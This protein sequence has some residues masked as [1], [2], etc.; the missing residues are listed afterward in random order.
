MGQDGLCKMK[1]RRVS[2]IMIVE[3]GDFDDI[4]AIA[5][6]YPGKTT[7]EKRRMIRE[8]L[9]PE[10]EASREGR[11]T[12][13]LA[14]RDGVVVGTVQVVWEDAEEEPALLPPG[15]AVVHHLGTHP[16]YRRLGIG[17][18]LMEEAES[19]A[20][21]RKVGE[22]TL[23]VEPENVEAHRLYEKWGF[24]D[25]LSYRGQDGEPIVGMKKR[26]ILA[27]E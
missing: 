7:R 9:G 17:R 22:L 4:A 12:I 16:D 5:E 19:L 8:S 21:A 2:P 24:R 20:R 23:G 6:L 14:R 13:L 25:F 18:R 11:R 15:A 3:A 1:G 27:S 10:F 26:L